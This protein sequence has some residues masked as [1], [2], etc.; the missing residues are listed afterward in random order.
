[1][2]KVLKNSALK[3]VELLKE[4]G[5]TIAT[6]ESCTGGMLSALITSVSGSSSVFEL[7][8]VSYASRIKNEILGVSK[9]TLSEFGAVSHQT[10]TEMAEK[11]RLKADADIGVSVTGVAGPLPSENKPVGLVYIAL[12]SKISQT[13]KELRIEPLG[14]DYIRQSACLELLNMI[15]NFIQNGV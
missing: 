4:K 7:G 13:V 10:A 5:L 1:M 2:E 15:C 9:S 3:T 14:R 11:V 8:V 12:S 6:A